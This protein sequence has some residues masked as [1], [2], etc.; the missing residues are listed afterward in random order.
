VTAGQPV[1]LHWLSCQCGQKQY[2]APM[3]LSPTTGAIWY[4]QGSRLVA[5]PEPEPLPMPEYALVVAQGG[6]GRHYATRIDRI[7]GKVS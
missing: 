1:E 3:R 5:V 7:N 2:R 4:V 6:E